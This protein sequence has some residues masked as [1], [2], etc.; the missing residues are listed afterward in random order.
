MASSATPKRIL[1]FVAPLSTIGMMFT[2]VTSRPLQ[3]TSMPCLSTTMPAASQIKPTI[4]MM[5]ILVISQILVTNQLNVLVA[6]E[7]FHGRTDE[8]FE[9]V[10]K[11][12]KGRVR[13]KFGIARGQQRQK[14]RDI[15]LVDARVLEQ[16][17]DVGG[18]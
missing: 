12:I 15:M 13:V 4:R 3:M 5:M 17:E 7:L 2:S 14:A 1:R 11:L 6:H 16:A 18:V 9:L 8:R 10:L